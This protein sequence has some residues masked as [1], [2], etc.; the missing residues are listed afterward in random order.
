MSCREL[1]KN[2]KILPVCSQQIHCL[3][4]LG[5]K[6]KDQ[7]KLNQEIHSIYSGYSSNLHLPT[8]NLAIQ[9]EAYSSGIE[10][11]SHHPSSK[12]SLSNEM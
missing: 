5:V 1:F 7:N 4:L 12:K 11:F 10:V 9:M 2:V 8:S 3:S 6:K